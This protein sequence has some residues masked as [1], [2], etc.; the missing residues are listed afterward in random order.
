MADPSKATK[1][2][3]WRASKH[4]DDVVRMMVEAELEFLRTDGA[5]THKN[6]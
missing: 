4:F 1:E 5:N 6:P 2:L 3:G